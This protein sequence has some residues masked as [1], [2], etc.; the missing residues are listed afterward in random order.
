MTHERETNKNL[1]VGLVYKKKRAAQEIDHEQD[2]D[3]DDDI[4]LFDSS[5]STPA[6]PSSSTAE[7]PSTPPVPQI[8]YS[9]ERSGLIDQI[10]VAVDLPVKQRRR[11]VRQ[12]PAD[13]LRKVIA[14]AQTVE[15]VEEMKSVLRGW[16]YLGKEVSEQNTEQIVG[17]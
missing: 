17:E 11:T 5:S 9:A 3:I 8:D 12:M 14:Y 13:N 15:D 4:D 6:T 2:E 16:R 7:T 1:T 10:R